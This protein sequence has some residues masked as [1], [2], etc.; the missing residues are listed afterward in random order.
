MYKNHNYIIELVKKFIDDPYN[1]P[2]KDIDIIKDYYYISVSNLLFV[3]R[4]NLQ[5]GANKN[6]QQIYFKSEL[7]DD[8]ILIYN[9]V[10][11]KF[12][13]KYNK[14]NS[15][16]N[17]SSYYY[18]IYKTRHY[19]QSN[20]YSNTLGDNKS[21]DLI[22]KI[23]NSISNNVNDTNKSKCLFCSII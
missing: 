18:D 1:F 21:N 12:T 4:K 16:I 2:E 10:Y 9:F 13:I 14:Y 6:K 20:D 19:N 11:D 23:N 7:T 5:I 3:S 17:K 8:Y 15:T 22:L